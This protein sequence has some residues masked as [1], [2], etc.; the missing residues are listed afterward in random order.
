[1]PNIKQAAV[2]STTHLLFCLFLSLLFVS[3]SFHANARPLAV[4][5]AHPLATDVGLEILNKGGNAFDAAVAVT[6]TL[7]VVEPYSSGIGGGGFWLLHISE[8][9]RDVMIDGRERAPLKASPDMYLDQH[10]NVIPDASINGPLAAGIPG[11]PAAIEHLALNYG[12]LPLAVTL[13]AAIKYARNGFR[14]N[15]RY[16][17]MAEFREKALNASADAARIFLKDSKAP[18]PGTLIVQ[19][20]LADTLTVIANQGA[21]GFYQGEIA[22]KLVASVARHG[23]IWSLEDLASYKIIE[24]APLVG[25]YRDMKI[26]S[27]APPSSGGVAIIQMLNTLENFDFHSMP[28]ASRIHLLS[29]IMRRAYRDRAEFLGDPDYVDVPVEQLVSEA[30]AAQLAGSIELDAAT[31]SAELKPVTVDGPKG[32]DTTHFSI[33][34]E[35]GNR[36]SATLSINYPFGSC[37]VAKG[38]GVLLNDEMDDFSSKPGEP[39]VYGLVG[40]DANA[41][42]PGKRMLS[43]MTPTFLETEERLAVL[44]TP[45]G[46]RIISMVLIAALEFYEG[47]SAQDIVNRGRFHH[48]YLPDRISYEPDVISAV[49]EDALFQLGHDT[50]MLDSTYGDMHAVVLDKKTR[51]LDAA[52]DFRGV[53]KARVVH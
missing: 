5:S 48:Q 14:T 45:G 12:K 39:N 10:D 47:G 35:Q 32:R 11:V 16:R 23:G 52:S 40:A 33:I 21:R 22:N 1:M 3:V 38:T 18:A 17:Q 30:Y 34:D 27:V 50:S 25:E 2:N 26:V 42:E 19:P 13:E 37:F 29:E 51:Q 31:A 46:S 36:V 28:E 44:G 53:G 6:A 15:E 43:S 9:D 7:A 24:R 49:V 4:A 20:E 8:N 41:I